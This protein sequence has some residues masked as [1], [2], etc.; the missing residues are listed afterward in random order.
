MRKIFIALLVLSSALSFG[1]TM[2][3]Q[4]AKSLIGRTVLLSIDGHVERTF[5]GK[6]GFYDATSSWTS[7]CANVRGP[8]VSGQYFDVE[9]MDSSKVGGNIT[10]AGNIVGKY[11]NEAKTPDQCAGLQLAVWEA[12]EDGGD[13][14]DF[15]NG[16]FQAQASPSVIGYAQKYYKARAQFFRIYFV[17]ATLGQSQMLPIPTS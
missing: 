4:F 1:E 15:Q 2:T 3:V 14:P 10:K 7:V 12:I 8:I 5:A 9:L 17:Y 16:H 13:E 11:F 6:L